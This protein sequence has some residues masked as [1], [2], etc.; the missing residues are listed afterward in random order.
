[1]DQCIIPECYID[2]KLIK[3][4]VPPKGRYNHQHGTNAFSIMQPDDKVKKRKAGILH[5]TFAL[6]IVDEDFEE[7]EYPR[8]CNLIYQLPGKLKLKK[9]PLKHHY[10][11]MICPEFEK[12]LI[13]QVKEMGSTLEEYGL[14]SD[15]DQLERITKTSKSE[16]QDPYSDNFKRLFKDLREYN[17]TSIALIRLWITYLK[18]NPYNADLVHLVAET[19]KL[20]Q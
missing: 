1:M 4:I 14:P 11:I 15:L 2:T 18:E 6:A 13:G 19:D 17:T 9:H 8:E 10:F 20:C 3:M 16:N 12:W 7:R 5:D